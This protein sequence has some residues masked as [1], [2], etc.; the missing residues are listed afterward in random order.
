MQPDPPLGYLLDHPSAPPAGRDELAAI[1]AKS[2][3][4]RTRLAAA[5]MAAAL[6]VGGAGGWAVANR[7]T[8][9]GRVQT[10]S[11]L[12]APRSATTTLPPGISGAD[13][14]KAAGAQI[15]FKRLFVRTTA[16][17][18]TVR[19]FEMDFAQ[20]PVDTSCSAALPIFQ[21]ELSTS[22]MVSNSVT[23]VADTSAA[24]SGTVAVVGQPEQSPVWTANAHAAAGIAMVRVH[25]A[26]GS[27]DQMAPVAG[28]VALA[29][30]APTRLAKG[31]TTATL[32]GLDPQGKV[33]ASAQLD[34]SKGAFLKPSPACLAPKGSSPVGPTTSIKLQR[35]AVFPPA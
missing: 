15:A 20:S 31:P 26:D 35:P 11:A 3:R 29:H 2:G 9:R 4:Q 21:S 27:T 6:V 22:G 25:F 12:G 23:P 18:V 7:S 24:L 10:A 14:A 8:D 17:G 5:G 16:D 28:W 19:G 33:I 34:Q 32:E 1:V 13:A 30:T